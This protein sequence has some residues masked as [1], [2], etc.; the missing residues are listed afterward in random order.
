MMHT[1]VCCVLGPTVAASQQLGP[2]VW[3]RIIRIVQEC[4]QDCE[5]NNKTMSC[6]C[7]C[8]CEARCAHAVHLQ[9]RSS[10]AQAR[11]LLHFVA[12]VFDCGVDLIRQAG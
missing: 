9:P 10:T 7:Q 4:W 3:G 12:L 6:L 5:R 2:Y 11:G 1:R 8:I